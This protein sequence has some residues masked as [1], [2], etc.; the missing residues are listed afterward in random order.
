VSTLEKKVADS[1]AAL[2][3]MKTAAEKKFGEIQQQVCN[4]RD[5]F[6]HNVTY[7]CLL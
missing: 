1:E 6:I 3:R 4:I 7:S 2:Q 5:L